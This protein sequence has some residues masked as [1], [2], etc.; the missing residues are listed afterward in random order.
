MQLKD[1]VVDFQNLRKHTLVVNLW[2]DL[3]GI[4]GPFLEAVGLRVGQEGWSFRVIQVILVE[5]AVL[6]FCDTAFLMVA[7]CTA[8]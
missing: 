7:S 8:L 2:S 5:A 6:D 3:L 1:E 4:A